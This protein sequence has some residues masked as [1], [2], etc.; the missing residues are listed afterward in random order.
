LQSTG[1]NEAGAQG[2]ALILVHGRGFKPAKADLERLWTSALTVGLRRD[3]PEAIEAFQKTPREFVYYGEEIRSVLNG[4][5]R[6]HDPALDLADLENTLS[7]LSALEKT[8]QF[9][10]EYYERLPGKTSLKEFLADVGAPALALVGLAD[11]AIARHLPELADYWRADGALQ[12]AGARLCDALAAAMDRSRDIV[13]VSH[14]IGSVIA[15]DALWTLSRGGF[16]DGRYADRKVKLWLTLGSPLGDESVKRHLRGA[17]ADGDR[18]YPSN[19]V[20]WLNIAAEDDYLCHDRDVANDFRS[21]LAMRLVSRI[22][23]VSIYNM[24]LR[25]GRSNPHNALGYLVH[26]RVARALANWLVA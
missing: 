10:R 25:Y 7:S 11:R 1:G 8:K 4:A 23:D 16:R 3:R 20:N 14:C 22:E 2:R 17:D 12:R 6:R 15:Y 19:V 26:P 9:R 21:M 13:L 5:G 24:A 18:R